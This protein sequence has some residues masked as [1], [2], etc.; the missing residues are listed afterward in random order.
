MLAHQSGRPN[1]GFCLLR[2]RGYFNEN[3][4]RGQLE[5]GRSLGYDDRGMRRSLGHLFLIT[6]CRPPAE[7]GRPRCS[8][9]PACVQDESP[10]PSDL[11]R[12]LRSPSPRPP[13]RSSSSSLL[14]RSSRALRLLLLSSSRKNNRSTLNYFSSKARASLICPF[15]FKLL[16]YLPRLE[17]SSRPTSNIFISPLNIDQPIIMSLEARVYPDPCIDRRS[18][19]LRSFMVFF[20]NCNRN[21]LDPLDPL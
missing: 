7:S 10:P 5:L 3:P 8:R 14:R 15:A 16:G 9:S 13:P 18:I 2:R 19:P 17:K 11:P 1:G 20:P 12:S 6:L 21:A 4:E